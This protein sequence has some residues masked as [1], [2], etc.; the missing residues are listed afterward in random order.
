MD[1]LHLDPKC[2][3]ALRDVG[4]LEELASLDLGLGDPTAPRM[5]G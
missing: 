4:A 2:Q 1:S 5:P 3:L